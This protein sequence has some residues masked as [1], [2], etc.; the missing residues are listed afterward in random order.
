M[1]DRQT[2]VALTQSGSSRRQVCCG[3]GA[4]LFQATA[5]GQ[6]P[7]VWRLAWLSPADGPGPN[8]AAF[9]SRMKQLGYEEG[10][11][12]EI[13]WAWVGSNTAALPAQASRLVQAKPDLILTQSQICAQAAQKATSTIPIVF[14]G[15]RDAVAAGLVRSY[16][17]PGGNLTGVTLTPSDE[18][19]GKLLELLRQLLPMAKR[20]GVFWNP[21]VPI[22]ASVVDLL[23]SKGKVLGLEVRPMPVKLPGDIERS[24]GEMVRERVEGLLTLVEWFTLTN[25]ELIARLAVEYR[26]PTLFEVKDYVVAGGLLAYGVVYHEHYASA[27]HYVDK[28]LKGAKPADLPVQ[29]PAKLEMI[30]NRRTARA[31]GLSIPGAVLVRADELID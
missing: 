27:A 19:V 31:I 26:I 25:R 16:A 7:K 20:I 13:E 2:V 18:L 21:G 17:N 12:F 6:N 30:V 8:H 29:Q 28:I 4:L 11:Q 24:F 22:Q 14:V 1:N 9:L 3:A 10:K 5:F 23:T 15:V